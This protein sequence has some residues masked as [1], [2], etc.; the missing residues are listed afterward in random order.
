MIIYLKFALGY[1]RR[2]SRNFTIALITPLTLPFYASFTSCILLHTRLNIALRLP[3]FCFYK[4]L[5]DYI[6]EICAKVPPEALSKF[7][8]C[9]NYAANLPFYTSFTSYIF[10]HRLKSVHSVSVF[11]FLMS[12]GS[13]AIFLHLQSTSKSNPST[14]LLQFTQLHT[15]LQ[16]T[17]HS[18]LPVSFLLIFPSFSTAPFPFLRES[19]LSS[20]G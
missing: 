8:D 14:F 15:M 20:S 5:G 3:T 16:S 13:A 1:R 4:I 17:F 10:L 11:S 6:S 12:L 18:G 2:R 19:K 9:I 7:Y